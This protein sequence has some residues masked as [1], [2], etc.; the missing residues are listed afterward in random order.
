MKIS[1][2]ITDES[3]VIDSTAVAESIPDDAVLAVSG[4]GSV[5]Y[6]KA[7]PL[8]LAK[9]KRNLSLTVISGGSVGDEIDTVLMEADAIARRYPYQARDAARDAVNAGRIEF[10]DRHIARLGEAVLLGQIPSPDVAVVEAVAVGTGWLVPSTS[11]GLT[12][13]YVEAADR[14][15]VEVN[16]AQPLSLQKFHDVYRVGTPPRNEPIPLSGPG[17][18]IGGPKITFDPRKLDAVVETEVRD[19]PYTFR[20]STRIDE[21]IAENLAAFLRE[22]QEQNPALKDSIRI[23]FG[24]GNLGNALMSAFESVDFGGAE[25]VYY[26]EVIQD[27]LLD[28][29]DSGR[30]EV[31][32]ATSLALTAEGQDRLFERFERY[33]E[34]IIL[35]PAY[36]TN[37]ASLVDR[38]GVISVNTALEVDLYGHVNST[39]IDGTQIV[40]GIG[41]SGDFTRNGLLSVIALGSKAGDGRISRI[42]PMV[43]HVDHTEHDIGVIVTEHGVADLRGLSPHERAS[44]LIDNCAD[45]AFRTDLQSYFDMASDQAGHIPH[46]LSSAFHWRSDW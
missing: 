40:N 35:R 4:F 11:I 6:P 36:I 31:A 27:G 33:V 29:I 17:E 46:D 9:S 23:Q 24:V 38:F 12:P 26:G 43:P 21:A 34:D 2:R 13:E 39:H 10:Q 5:G 45:P 32:S 28:L 18:R 7:V 44:E 22:E 37:R 25:I 42:V 19:Q 20:D 16:H 3:A 41:G 30:V 15:I 8:A 14:L 1:N